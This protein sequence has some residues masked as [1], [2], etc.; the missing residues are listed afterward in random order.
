MRNLPVHW[1]EG[2]FL[3]P[4]HLQ[5]A[6]RYWAELIHTS[7]RWD[8][9]YGYGLYHV[10]F[11]DDALANHQLQIHSLH[12]RM[13]DGTLVQFDSGQEPDRV[14]LKAAFES[15]TVI[16]AYVA[17]PKLT[18]GRANVAEPGGDGA[19]RFTSIDQSVQD[20]SHG[21]NDQQLQFRSLNARIL[22]ST[23]DTSGYELIPIARIKRSGEGEATPKIDH[24]YIP[25]LL[26]IDCW[27][28]LGRDC[29][30]AI[31]D[32]IGG[33]IEVLSQQ[34]VNRGIGLNSQEPG[35]ADR[36]LMLNQLNAAYATL[37]VMAFAQGVHP[38]DAYTELCRTLGQLAIFDENRRVAEVPR[39]D[40]DDLSRVFWQVRDRIE[41]L[42]NAVRDYE[43]RQ[44][45]FEGIGMGM[46][47]SLEPQWFHADWQWYVGVRKGDLTNQEVGDLLS[48]GQLDWKI[49]S[50]RQVEMLFRQ[51]AQGLQLT[52]LDRAVRA[53]PARQ[54]WLYYQVPRQDNPAWRD[55]QETQTI[56]IRVRD[57]LIQN[58]DRLQGE[59]TM[60]VSAWGRN[61]PLEFALFAVP[62]QS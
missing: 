32:M 48:S 60:V 44:R 40:H 4:Q 25:P 58:L 59:R 7:Q 23:E 26:T 12:A 20:E 3:R 53:L 24:S 19:A 36:I 54:D 49:G 46:Q 22:L 45:F 18:M 50:S 38:L 8:R 55:V 61:I 21:G 31:Y 42:I 29:V 52:P 41:M 16:D 15:E 57:S 11:S 14:D 27:P 34:L 33:K 13:R 37:G 2:L 17:V 10:E 56:A 47:A 28:A 9:S 5:A 6:D 43:Y 30:R 1:Y 35:D 62:E 51:R 39:Y